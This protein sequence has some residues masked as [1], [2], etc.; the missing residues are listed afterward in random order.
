MIGCTCAVCRSTDPHDKRTRC[1]V[2]ISYNNVR[3]LVDTTP[4]LR[5]QCLAQD[6]GWD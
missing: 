2:V 3:V 6:I 1:S 4:E 5:V